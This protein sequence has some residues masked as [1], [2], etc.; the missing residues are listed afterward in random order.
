MCKIIIAD[1]TL[2][3]FECVTYN[4]K[5]ISNLKECAL[6]GI[7]FRSSTKEVINL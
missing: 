5:V 4:T 7:L 6:M 1:I 3:I 2:K